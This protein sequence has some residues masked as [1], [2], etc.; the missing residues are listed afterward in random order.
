[1]SELNNQQISHLRSTITKM[2]HSINAIDEAVIWANKKSN[3]WKCGSSSHLSRFC[4]IFQI[5]GTKNLL[6]KRLMPLL[7]HQD[8]GM[9]SHTPNAHRRDHLVRRDANFDAN[10]GGIPCGIESNAIYAHSNATSRVHHE[11]S[12]EARDG[13]WQPI[14]SNLSENHF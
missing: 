4:L 14:S 5:F 2:E 1:M 10:Y 9:S 13:D 8:L 7:T 6:N 11:V 12:S 3:I